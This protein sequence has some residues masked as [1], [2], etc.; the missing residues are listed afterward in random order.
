LLFVSCCP[1]DEHTWYPEGTFRYYN[2]HDTI[3]FENSVTG[4]CTEFP[5]CK[6]E[7][8]FYLSEDY[9]RC[10]QKWYT[11]TLNYVLA[12]DSCP[13]DREIAIN[14]DPSST[15]FIVIISRYSDSIKD[16]LWDSYLDSEKMTVSILG[17]TYENTVLISGDYQDSIRNVT[18]SLEYGILQFILNDEI[19]SFKN[20][21]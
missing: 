16:R 12:W 2:E 7:T 5:V 15:A 20:D 14:I 17:K 10:N 8:R 13:N 19:Y 6:R 1:D 3:R 18:F 9:D 21:E 11:H 4:I